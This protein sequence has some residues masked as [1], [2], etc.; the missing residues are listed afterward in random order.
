MTSSCAGHR[1]HGAQASTMRSAA[2]FARASMSRARASTSLPRAIAAASCASA[3]SA[4]VSASRSIHDI[5]WIASSSWRCNALAW[6]IARSAA[7]AFAASGSSCP[8]TSRS[9]R[10]ASSSS[11]RVASAAAVACSSSPIRI[12]ASPSS[13]SAAAR[14]P[15]AANSWRLR[16]L[17]PLLE[18]CGRLHRRLRRG[19]RRREVLLEL[20]RLR[21]GLVGGRLRRR[22]L[23]RDPALEILN[24]ILER[25]RS[26]SRSR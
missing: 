7:P 13:D 15:S 12:R 19:L 8:S 5:F 25:R 22:L 10:S 14:A 24:A 21:R 16:R 18:R 26:A 23:D 4:R 9:R 11:V 6:P 1:G 17:D 2:S 3:S 20:R